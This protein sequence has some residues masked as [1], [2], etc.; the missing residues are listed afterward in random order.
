MTDPTL[1]EQYLRDANPI[2]H[3]DDLDPE[4]FAR[5]VSVA[6]TRRAAAMQTP[7][8]TPARP[9]PTPPQGGKGWAFALAIALVLA[10][11]GITALMLRNGEG[12]VTDEPAPAT[13]V[14]E[15]PST[16]LET[17]TEPIQIESLTWAEV[18]S[19][20]WS[21][22]PEI[23]GLAEIGDVTVGGPGLVAVGRGIWT[24]S[25]GLTWSLVHP[26]LIGGPYV[27][28]GSVTAGG[29][30]LVAVGMQW[31][32]DTTNHVVPPFTYEPPITSG[33]AGVWT[34]QDGI[35]WARVPNDQQVFGPGT[36]LRSVTTGGPGLVAVGWEHNGTKFRPAV[37]TSP[38]GFTWSR[39]L[40]GQAAFGD[41]RMVSVAAGGPG[42]VAVGE[43]ELSAAVWTSP[44][45]LTWSRV[46]HDERAFSPVTAMRKVIAGGPGLV[47][48]GLDDMHA[49]GEGDRPAVWTST[50]GVFWFR[51]PHDEQV[52]G[53]TPPRAD[54]DVEMRSVTAVGNGLVAVGSGGAVWKS[55]DG[56]TW[57]RV[58]DDKGVFGSA[59]LSQVINW[60]SG[61]VAL[62]WGDWT[63]ANGMVWMAIPES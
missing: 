25:D 13:S 4:E 50:D 12:A 5:F 38:D 59:E 39:V 36:N 47:A 27:G 45:G 41:G 15:T 18:E 20:N 7:T 48:V 56:V 28:W 63:D 34:S 2:A 14:P 46:A 51:V 52:F 33:V 11:I 35:T 23:P 40:L 55:P 6:N 8:R 32:S 1:I 9:A 29:P 17:P 16:A 10:G 19:L 53:F 54:S 42:L 31:S 24:S 44:D 58:P 60:D 49:G 26:E 37:W 22:A 21:R 61:L 30:G 62:G 57:S 3:L 43:A